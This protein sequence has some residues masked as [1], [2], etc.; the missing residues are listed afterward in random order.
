MS[1]R[2]AIVGAAV[3]APYYLEAIR[4]LPGGK[5]KGKKRGRSR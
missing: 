3:V 5:E 4:G 1:H 2:F